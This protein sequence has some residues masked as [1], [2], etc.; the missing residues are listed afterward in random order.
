MRI[1][2]GSTLLALDLN[3]QQ[4]LANNPQNTMELLL[5]D[6]SYSN[7]VMVLNQG[8]AEEALMVD[9]DTNFPSYTS[10][11]NLPLFLSLIHI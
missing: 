9:Q 3:P 6:I 2:A 11:V 8:T 1:H 5:G 4:Q 7:I 10:S